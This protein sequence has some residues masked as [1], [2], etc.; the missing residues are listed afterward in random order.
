MTSIRARKSFDAERLREL[1]TGPGT[2]SRFWVSCGR[3]A[4]DG[5][6]WDNELGPVVDVE[7]Y[8]GE[9]EGVEVTCRVAAPVTGDGFGEFVPIQD[10]EEVL[11]AI[12][13]G[14]PEAGP[15]VIGYMSNA[16]SP[17]FGDVAGLSPGDPLGLE[18]KRSPYGRAEQY[19]GD[20]TLQAANISRRADES[21]EI[22]ALQE[23]T[24]KA[25]IQAIIESP[26]ILAKGDLIKLGESAVSPV[27]LGTPF[28]AAQTPMWAAISTALTKLAGAA[29]P[30]AV[31]TELT[32]A[33]TAITTYTGAL[34]ASVSIKTLAE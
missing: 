25:D 18:L 20:H 4:E 8:G 14:D 24:L 21:A 16:G 28:I 12:P 23:A 33:V 17:V 2:D 10:G 27:V 13:D 3:V 22:Y 1:V 32:A 34:P 26:L 29:T 31:E 11:V 9:S 15:V 5:A 30:V 7:L 6:R 19:D